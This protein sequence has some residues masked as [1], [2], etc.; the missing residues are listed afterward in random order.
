MHQRL[1]PQKNGHELMAKATGLDANRCAAG[2]YWARL[3]DGKERKP[4][5]MEMRSGRWWYMG[6]MEILGKVEPYRKREEP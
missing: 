6:R 2:Y 1:D 5:I 3:K 4:K